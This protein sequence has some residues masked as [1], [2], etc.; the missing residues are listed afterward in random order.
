MVHVLHLRYVVFLQDLE[1]GLA[2]LHTV[3]CAH[4][5]AKVTDADDL[6]QVK[7]CYRGLHDGRSAWLSV[8]CGAARRQEQGHGALVVELAVSHAQRT[9]MTRSR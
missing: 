6:V 7:V 5:L 3:E 2:L 8:T 9:A 4:D 1:G